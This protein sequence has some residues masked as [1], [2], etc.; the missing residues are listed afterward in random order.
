MLVV[1][2]FDVL[3]GVLDH[4]HRGI[5]HGTDGDRNAAERHD[6]RIHSLVDHDSKGDQDTQGQGD[7]RHKCGAKVKQENHANEGDNDEFLD[8]LLREVLHCAFDQP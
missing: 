1:P 5:D 7:D 3:V 4:H 8:Q 2:G 6:V